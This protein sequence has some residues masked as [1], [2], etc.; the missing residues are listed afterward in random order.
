MSIMYL[1]G[2]IAI[3]IVPYIADLL[4]RRTGIVIGCSIMLCGVAMVSIGFHIAIFIVGRFLLG[5][6][7]GIAQ[8]SD[9]LIRHFE[10]LS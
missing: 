8:V 1:G 2:V 10:I 3:P 7:L 6:G 4:G 5:F 9:L